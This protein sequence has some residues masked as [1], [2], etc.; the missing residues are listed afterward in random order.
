M[1]AN[2]IYLRALFRS[3]THLNCRSWL[4]RSIPRIYW[5]ALF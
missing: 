2:K 4:P 1:R 5:D 3:P